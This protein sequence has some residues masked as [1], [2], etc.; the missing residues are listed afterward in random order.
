MSDLRLKGW[1]LQK[2]LAAE[3]NHYY[4][5]REK[6]MLEKNHLQNL[7]NVPNDRFF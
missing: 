5:H 4:L 2:G 6:S 1:T 3:G 7:K